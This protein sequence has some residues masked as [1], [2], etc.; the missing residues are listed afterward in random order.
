VDLIVQLIIYWTRSY[1]NIKE[2]EM[3]ATTFEE[4]WMAR[5]QAAE[6]FVRGDGG[7][8]DALVPHEGSASFHSPRGD[9][10]VGAQDVALRYSAEAKI[11]H[12]NGTT[13]LEAIQR[14]HAGDLGFWTGFQIARVQMEDAPQPVEMRIR[15]TELFRRI[16]GEWRLIHR[17][18]DIPKT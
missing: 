14:A 16:E 7:K 5:Q 17:H 12:S 9:T 3:T 15:V 1:R 6:A 18:A 8:L 10:V 2:R 11:F 13:H 4:F